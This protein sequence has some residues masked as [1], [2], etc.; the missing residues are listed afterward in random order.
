MG[1]GEMVIHFLSAVCINR[2]VIF[3]I[4]SRGGPVICEM[5]LFLVEVTC[6]FTLG[7]GRRRRPRRAKEVIRFRS[8][9]GAPGGVCGKIGGGDSQRWANRKDKSP[10]F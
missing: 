8:R 9:R 7:D 3:P 10:Y 2:S 5:V 6:V 1:D 4:S